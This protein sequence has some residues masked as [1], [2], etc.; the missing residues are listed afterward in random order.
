M[1]KTKIHPRGFSAT[2]VGTGQEVVDGDAEATALYREYMADHSVVRDWG[3]M[4]RLFITQKRL[5]GT[6]L[7]YWVTKQLENRFLDNDAIRFVGDTIRMIDSGVR[8]IQPVSYLALLTNGPKEGVGDVRAVKLT[9]AQL[10]VVKEL[11]TT[12]YTKWI[13]H[14]NGIGDLV[15]TLYVLYGEMDVNAAYEAAGGNVIQS[16]KNHKIQLLQQ[17][18]K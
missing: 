6:S 9:P 1:Q 12:F 13:F 17:A 15:S 7:H 14:R 5:M 11:D 16:P 8:M 10:D 18:L 4:K 2:V 3:W